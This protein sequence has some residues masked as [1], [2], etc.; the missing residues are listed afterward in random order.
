RS[1]FDSQAGPASPFRQVADRAGAPGDSLAPLLAR[2]TARLEERLGKAPLRTGA[3]L[4]AAGL[5]ARARDEAFFRDRAMLRAAARLAGDDPAAR[6]AL[7]RV[8]AALPDDEP[9]RWSELPAAL[10]A[11]LTELA[12][13]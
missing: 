12:S 13:E 1:R 11:L 6:V 3:W 7:A 5:A 2:G 4:E 8:R 10:D 9:P